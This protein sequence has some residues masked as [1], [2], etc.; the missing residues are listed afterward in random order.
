MLKSGAIALVLSSLAGSAWAA[1]AV[2][3]KPAD[4]GALQAIA[5]QQ[6]LMVSGLSCDALPRYNAFQTV[7]Q[8]ELRAQDRLLMQFMKRV[9]G[10]KGEAQYH[11]FKTRA[12]NVAQLRY[13][14]DPLG[15]CSNTAEA[16]KS[17]L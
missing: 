4:I 1:T 12:A 11:A 6:E 3:A 16:F 5:V 9:G 7:F 13:I 10:A 2:C 14:H 8:M 17:A 15:F